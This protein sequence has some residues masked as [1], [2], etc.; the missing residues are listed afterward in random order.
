MP[1]MPFRTSAP[2]AASTG[3][4]S[5][6]PDGLPAL[7][8]GPRRW[9][10]A[11]LVLWTGLAGASGVAMHG[12]GQ[13]ACAPAQAMLVVEIPAGGFTKYEIGGDGRVHVDRFLSMPVVY[14]ANYG[15]MPGTLAGD[16]DP[17]DALVI[18]RAPLH[19]GVLVRF[20]PVGVLRMT[21]SGEADDKIIG[22]PAD[23][24]D[25]HY[26]QVR[27]IGDL[28][29]MELARIEAFFRVYKGLPDAGAGNPVQLGGFGNAAEARTMISDALLQ[30]DAVRSPTTCAGLP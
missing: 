24:V 29:P 13:P 22:V 17:L 26:A 18:T 6:L 7:V 15:S 27:D 30:E 23:G 3:S 20:R 5:R 25:P 4:D 21:D 12:A 9:L 14:P 8:P 10:A 16:G 11:V 1:H 19:P 2:P 28:A